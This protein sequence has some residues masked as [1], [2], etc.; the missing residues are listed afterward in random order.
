MEILP[1]KL[2]EVLIIGA[3]P[4]GLTAALFL[5]QQNLATPIV[6]E[7]E[8]K[9]GGLSRTEPY[10][11]NLIDLGGHRFFTRS[12]EVLKIWQSLLPLQGKPA[13]DDK[14][15]HRSPRLEPEGPDPE[16]VDRV[17]LSRNRV[18]R[19]YFRGRFFSYPLAL[20]FA[21][22]KNLGFKLTL[23]IAWAYFFAMLS[24]RPVKSL[25]D[26]YIN[27][28]GK[29]L[30]Q[31]FFEDYT[32]KLW[33]RH[34][35]EISPDWGAQRIRGLSLSRAILSAMAKPF[36]NSQ[37]TETSLIE[38]FYYPKLG[39]GQLWQTMADQIIELGGRIIL[40][41]RVEKITLTGSDDQSRY[42]VFVTD[43]NQHEH[44]YSGE[45]LFSS[46]AIRDLI[47]AINPEPP[48]RIRQLAAALPYR[49]FITCGVLVRR[50][51]VVNQTK[52]PTLNNQIPDNWIYI[53]DRSVKIGR[54][55][56]FNNWS[57]YLVADPEN[58]VW[59]GLEYFANEGDELWSMPDA[60][61]KSMAAQ[62]LAAIG[63]IDVDQVLDQVVF[64]IPK[65][66]PAYFDS[67]RDFSEIRDY[68]QTL[69]KL[70]CIGRNGQHRYNNM[71]HSMLTALEA[72][73]C[74]KDQSTLE[75]LWAVN[76]DEVYNG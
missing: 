37:R 73:R 68:L 45:A 67:Y 6:I 74:Y 18:S 52:I 19:I 59:I 4:A 27:R 75:N 24:P 22:I 42:Q 39:P 60:E 51:K 41:S 30:Y 43:L 64:K 32:A 66:Y 36:K 57:P 65:A 54:L 50:L 25:E 5:V 17:M 7:S 55:Q 63:L 58:T 9:V 40:G 38:S 3:G 49:D 70:Y 33:G 46:M 8:N 23:Q 15:L 34:P 62:E 69:P 10:H 1:S 28:F 26:F 56:I 48:L 61:F 21:T 53:Q 44:S 72:I 35:R 31:L 2:P 14:L 20:N 29:K 71:D 76:A 13:F 12:E 47:S 16:Q 11:D